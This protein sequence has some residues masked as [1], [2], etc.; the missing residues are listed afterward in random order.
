MPD[1][2]YDSIGRVYRLYRQPDPRI[3]GQIMGALGEAVTILDVGAGTGSY[4]PKDR[5][6]VAAEPSRVMIS[7]RP[8]GSAPV[9]RSVA[10]RLPFASGSFDAVLAIFTVHHW[11][12]PRIGLQELA[13]VARRIVILHYDQEIHGRF[14]LFE[15]YLPEANSL[16]A[17]RTLDPSQ[18]ADEIGASRTETIPVP[19]DCIDGFNWAY[20]RRPERYLDPDARACISSI[21]LLHTDLVA[22]RMEKL[23]SDLSDGTWRRRHGHLMALDTVDAGLRLVIRD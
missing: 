20:W 1:A 7:Q 2:V 15:D 9:V 10:E 19:A 21:A 18:V 16:Y 12:S 4:E 17:A 22:E 23:R 5:Q 11:D 13:R 14:W 8:Q 3:A 6:V